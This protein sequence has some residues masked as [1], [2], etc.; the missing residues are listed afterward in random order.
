MHEL[1]SF[2]F[3]SAFKTCIAQ[4]SKNCQ[5]VQKLDFKGPLAMLNFPHTFYESK[6]LLTLK[7]FRRNR[8]YF[9]SLNILALPSPAEVLKIMQAM[10]VFV[11]RNSVLLSTV[12]TVTVNKNIGWDSYKLSQIFAKIWFDHYHPPS[13]NWEKYCK[14]YQNHLIICTTLCSGYNLSRFICT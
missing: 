3:K 5:L 10:K 14:C 11:L 4:N 2:N 9:N 12:A 6:N 8:S 1:Y 7:R 13:N